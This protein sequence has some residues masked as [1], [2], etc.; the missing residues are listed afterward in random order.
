VTAD[1]IAYACIA[2]AVGPMLAVSAVRPRTDR[3]RLAR[4][5]LW[6]TLPL[7]A[8]D[9]AANVLLVDMAGPGWVVYSAWGV[10][11]LLL[12][13]VAWAG[14]TVRAEWADWRAGERLAATER[15][16]WKRGRPSEKAN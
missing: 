3:W 12:A 16:P 13:A 4:R 5:V 11:V 6:V 14:G 10:F 2:L 1:W 8:A 15:R 9:V 7:A